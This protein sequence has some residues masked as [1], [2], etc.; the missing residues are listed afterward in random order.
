M[1]FYA[2]LWIVLGGPILLAKRKLEFYFQMLL[3]WGFV[4]VLFLFCFALL[5]F[6]VV[7]CFVL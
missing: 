4:F 2:H 1:F 3:V 6:A 7:F 5:F